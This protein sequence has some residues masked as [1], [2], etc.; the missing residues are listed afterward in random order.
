MKKFLLLILSFVLGLFA[1]VGCGET[2][3]DSY[4]EVETVEYDITYFVVVGNEDAAALTDT[5]KVEN[6]TYPTSYEEGDA[7]TFAALKDSIVVGEYTYS[8]K[9]WYTDA[10]C[11]TAITGVLETTKNDL[12]VYAKYEK[13][14]VSYTITYNV[15][16]D[17]QEPVALTDTYK[18]E[19]GE[20]PA[21]YEKGVG[22]T[23]S[24]L[25]E[26]VNV[27][28][29]DY[30]FKG[31]Y[32]NAA[33]SAALANNTIPTTNTGNV[34]LYAKYESADY[35]P[36]EPNEPVVY[37][38]TYFVVVNTNEPIVI[39]DAYK[40]QDAVYPASYEYGVGAQIPDAKAEVLATDGTV[41]FKG[42]FTNEECNVAFDGISETNLGEVT[43]Y[44]KY[45]TVY[46]TISYYAVLDGANPVALLDAWKVSGD[47]YP[48]T[49][50]Y[51]KAI[52]VDDLQAEITVNSTAYEFK[53]WYFDEGCTTSASITAT[54][55]GDQI[56]YAKYTKKVATPTPPE[57]DNENWTQNY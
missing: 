11:T 12:N 38:I 31:W 50:E 33:C 37:D 5:Y 45:E 10:A 41:V 32:I 56:L 52:D 23:V 2:T 22:A 15:V 57:D 21:T 29:V 42:W 40:A 4:E 27:S 49:Y 6:V 48:T 30:E 43:V 44:A 17:S 13:V 25:K 16:F 20:Y 18:A 1:F 36:E 34:V 39:T 46:Y 19:N 51:G 14:V 47:E 53:G 55:S 7:F 54:T 8:F 9:G 3:E 35:T 24:D 28:E 26:S